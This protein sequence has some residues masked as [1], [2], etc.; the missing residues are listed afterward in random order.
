MRIR[1][2]L[3]ANRGNVAMMFAMGIIPIFGMVGFAIDYTRASNARE[4]I[5][6]AVDS[7]A[8]SANKNPRLSLAQ[9]TQI[10]REI[11]AQQLSDASWISF[12]AS[13]SR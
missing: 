8:L 13:R 11:V 1:N 12:D 4:K 6:A 3:D 7:A 5:S 2:F 10:A 9:K